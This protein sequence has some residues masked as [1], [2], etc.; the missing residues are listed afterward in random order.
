[1]VGN[2]VVQRRVKN[3][4]QKNDGVIEELIWR[5]CSRAEQRSA[6]PS[7]RDRQPLAY[8]ELEGPRGRRGGDGK[9]SKMGLSIACDTWE[10]GF[11]NLLFLSQACSQDLPGKPF[12]KILLMLLPVD[13]SSRL[14]VSLRTNG[15]TQMGKMGLFVN[16][17]LCCMTL[18]PM[19]HCRSVTVGK[20]WN[21]HRLRF[22]HKTL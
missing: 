10:K 20:R 14:T 15:Q 2:T 8:R 4:A 9:E 1:M 22:L 17:L 12:G 19:D 7:P 18:P 21:E 11:K 5:A 3:V 16:A 13:R 6:W